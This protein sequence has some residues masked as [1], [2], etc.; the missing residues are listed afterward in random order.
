MN[1]C[2]YIHVLINERWKEGRNKQ[3][4]TARQSNTAHP[5]Y[6][7]DGT[8]VHNTLAKETKKGKVN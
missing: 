7:H 4:Q 8:Y 5:I 2:V 3:A 1:L 6:L